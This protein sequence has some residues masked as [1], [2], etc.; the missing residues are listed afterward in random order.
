MI[1]PLGPV[2]GGCPSST[3]RR[4]IASAH[5]ASV[6]PALLPCEGHR[7]ST[8]LSNKVPGRY[9]LPL[10]SGN[11]ISPAFPPSPAESRTCRMALD[12]YGLAR[13]LPDGPYGGERV[14]E[15]AGLARESWQQA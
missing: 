10:P 12:P 14:G 13:E 5:T 7:P 11:S 4:S 15:R 6:Q 8:R 1:N 9:Q 2:L 3:G